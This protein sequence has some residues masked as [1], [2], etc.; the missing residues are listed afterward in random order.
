MSEIHINSINI[1]MDDFQNY[2]RLINN[3]LNQKQ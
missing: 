1:R 3:I 2:L